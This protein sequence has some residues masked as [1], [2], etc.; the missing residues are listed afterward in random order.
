MVY[1]SD[2][3]F[4]LG[5]RQLLEASKGAFRLGYMHF[6]CR[7]TGARRAAV[8]PVGER[9]DGP[10]RAV[11]QRLDAAVATVADPA[12]KTKGP[13]LLAQ[14]PAES[15]TLHAATNAQGARG[16]GFVSG[17]CRPTLHPTPP[18]DAPKIGRY[19]HNPRS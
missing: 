2:E 16:Q 14:R 17:I 15:D 18:G 1:A 7:D 6:D 5:G 19:W 11:N 3:K 12:G 13:R 4:L 9:R 8:G 10:R